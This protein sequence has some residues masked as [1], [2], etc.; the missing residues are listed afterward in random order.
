VVNCPQCSQLRTRG[1]SGS[2]YI[3]VGK[4][5]CNNL[6]PIYVAEVYRL[7][8]STPPFPSH[9]ATAVTTVPRS[10]SNRFEALSDN[11]DQSE[12]QDDDDNE[13]VTA[14]LAIRDV[15][16]PLAPRTLES[17]GPS[18]R[19]HYSAP[20]RAS[21]AKV[22]SMLKRQLLQKERNTLSA[23]SVPNW[24]EQ[25]VPSRPPAPPPP[26]ICPCDFRMSTTRAI[27]RYT[28][29]RVLCA[30]V[31]NMATPDESPEAFSKTTT[32]TSS[33]TET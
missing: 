17:Y 7:L 27:E 32:T 6:S 4:P 28:D 21:R 10:V 15:A 14:S 33:S 1:L 26:S 13:A 23:S 3:S 5:K 2:G 16:R 24:L 9:L 12:D 30:I 31:N 29:S 22:R 25:Q 11:D 18:Y 19:V 20:Q 8:E